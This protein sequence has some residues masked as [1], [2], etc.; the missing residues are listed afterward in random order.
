MSSHY[1]P[2]DDARKCYDL[3]VE[4]KRQRGDKHWPE[5]PENLEPPHPQRKDFWMRCDGCDHK[6]VGL[7]TPMLLAEFAQCL[8]ETVCPSCGAD[9]N[10]FHIPA[11]EAKSDD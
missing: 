2:A 8:A 1:D 10:L 7:R 4:T 5:R 9:K 11:P 3:A 6:W